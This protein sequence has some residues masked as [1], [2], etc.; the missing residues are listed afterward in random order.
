MK[1][2][3][4]LLLLLCCILPFWLS[5]QPVQ[6]CHANEIRNERH[7]ADPAYQ[8]VQQQLQRQ[9]EIWLNNGRNLEK[10][11][12]VRT[13]PVVVHL[14]QSSSTVVIT[15]ARVQTQIDVMNE[16]YRR[17]NSDTNNLRT[18]FTPFAIDTEIEFCLATIDPVGCPTTGINRVIDANLST[19]HERTQEAA[20]KGLIQ[21]DPTRYLNIWVP[22]TMGNQLIGYST[23]PPGLATA[24]E[25]DGV[26]IG[27]PFFGR[28]AGVP[29]GDYNLGRTGTHEVGHW[30][31]L[32][33]PWLSGCTGLTPATCATAG[34][35][36]CD[37]PPQA[38]DHLGNCPVNQNT[39][40]ESPNYPDIVENFMQWTKD[41]CMNMFTQGQRDRMNFFLDSVRSDVWSPANLTS[42]GCDGTVSTGC[43]PFVDFAADVTNGCTGLTVSFTDLSSGIPN[44]TAWSWDFGD[45]G[46]STSQNPTHTYNSTGLFTVSLTATNANGTA[47]ESKMDLIVIGEGFNI[48]IAEGLENTAFPPAGWVI[49]DTDNEGSW[50]RSTDAA[51]TG[52]ASAVIKNYELDS[53]GTPDNFVSPLLNLR[54]AT[55]ADLSFQLAYKEF[56]FSAPDNPDRLKVEISTNCGNSW[57]TL[58]DEAGADLATTP[59]FDF[60]AF[61]PDTTQWQFFSFDLANYLGSSQTY[62]R[63]QNLGE[64][65]Q[66]LY[67]DDINIS[68]VVSVE[69]EILA[70]NWVE[71][72]PNPF[73]DQFEVSYWLDEPERVTF[74][75]MDLK[76]KTRFSEEMAHPVSGKNVWEMPSDVIQ[77]LP[78]GVYV[79]SIRT[80]SSIAHKK[81]IRL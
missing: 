7:L 20:L 17:M 42:T 56:G 9:Y 1:N 24:P 5:A 46:T 27:G 36:I 14:I 71:V 33:H 8:H 67:L 74:D 61:V 65:G 31:G 81:I 21:W 77:E 32:E 12:G 23:F 66:N 18:V 62:I 79:L 34:D 72:Y 75:L 35:Y 16:D 73:T 28:G 51:R 49:E 25:L 15:D 43:G 41:S 60:N 57:T 6:R 19:N 10:R 26:V 59:G 76:G 2:V 50:T 68:G 44:M 4:Q 11:G 48:P 47:T 13:I 70:Q 38:M 3:R 58:F 69:E 63:F 30:L 54:F 22:E 64:Y 78:A 29:F 53:Q 37:T 80:A 39:C 40:S 55:S 45:N 52:N